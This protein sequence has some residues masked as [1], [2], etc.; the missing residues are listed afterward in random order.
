M[1]SSFLDRFSEGSHYL[2]CLK[3][4]TV[5]PCRK[6]TLGS[7]V[8]YLCLLKRYVD[9]LTPGMGEFMYD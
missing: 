4:I 9:I 8:S 5:L 3:T 1:L 6:M 2:T 7:V